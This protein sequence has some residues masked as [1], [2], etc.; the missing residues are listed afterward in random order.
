MLHFL[1][2]AAVAR[3]LRLTPSRVAHREADR[4]RDRCLGLSRR[5]H[6]EEELFSLFWI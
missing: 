4:A 2:A 6:F 1:S 3:N 5:L